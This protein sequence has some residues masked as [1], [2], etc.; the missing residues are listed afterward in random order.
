MSVAQ[1]CQLHRQFLYL[2]LQP[3]LEVCDVVGT[4]MDPALGC[5][6]ELVTHRTHREQKNHAQHKGEDKGAGH[7]GLFKLLTCLFVMCVRFLAFFS[8]CLSFS[9]DGSFD[10]DVTNFRTE[11]LLQDL[12]LIFSWPLSSRSDI[13]IHLEDNQ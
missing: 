10:L 8:L 12:F 1:T 9:F 3:I 2:V 7:V 6:G 5:L 13:L 11:S 4:D